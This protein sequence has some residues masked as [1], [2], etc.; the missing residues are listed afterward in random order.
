[1]TKIHARM[2]SALLRRNG[3]NPTSSYGSNKRWHGLLVKQLGDSVSVRVW[4]DIHLDEASANDRA[5]VGEIAAILSGN[6]Y[7]VTP[8]ADAHYLHIDDKKA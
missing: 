5:V 6:G 3:Y 4:Q 2:I 7:K 1:M 8:G